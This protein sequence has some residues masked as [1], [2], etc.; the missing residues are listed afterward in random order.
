M[1]IQSSNWMGVLAVLSLAVLVSAC[2]GE[3]SVISTTDSVIDSPTVPGRPVSAPDGVDPELISTPAVGLPAFDSLRKLSYAPGDLI[4]QGSEFLPGEDYSALASVPASTT[5][6]LLEP[7]FDPAVPGSPA[8]YAYA[9]YGF[10]LEGYDLAA[11]VQLAVAQAQDYVNLWVAFSN[12]NATRWDIYP[13]DS[14]AALSF[15]PAQFAHFIAPGTAACYVALIA[16]GTQPWTIDSVSISE[17]QPPFADGAR[18]LFAG[19]SFFVPVALAFD[20]LAIAN[21]FSMHQM[22]SYFR[23]SASGSPR[24]LWEDPTSHEEIDALL[25]TGQIELFGL[26]SFV[27]DNSR[28]EDYAHW[29]NLALTYNPDTQFFIGTPWVSG[30]PSLPTETFETAND[31]IGETIFLVVD[32][33]RSDFPDQQ[34]YYLAYGKTASVMKRMYDAEELPDITQLT[35]PSPDALFVDAVTGHGGPMM[36]EMS[37]LSW[38]DV[39]YGTE[40][41]DL[42]ISPYESDVQA[43]LTEVLEHNQ[44][45]Q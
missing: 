23:G 38:L 20:D 15:T 26:T 22:E 18:C 42:V 10:T 1:S 37:A 36:L 45:Y 30:G 24:A 9:V 11:D 4:K 14:S 43:I 33:L 8:E 32:Q 35:G 39:L 27:E 31:T 6:L 21:E 19:H 44:P 17:V 13:L 29:V 25:A 34:I 12:W 16:T 40:L 7:N 3:G 2:T 5:Q 28:V 41:A